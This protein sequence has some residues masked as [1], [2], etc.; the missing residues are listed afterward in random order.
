M[1]RDPPNR[2]SSPPVGTPTAWGGPRGSGCRRT[3]AQGPHM[4]VQGQGQGTGGFGGSQPPPISPGCCRSSLPAGGGGSRGGVPDTPRGPRDPRRGHTG[5]PAGSHGIPGGAREQRRC[6]GM[7]GEPLTRPSPS[8]P[9]WPR[10]RRPPAPQPGLSRAPPGPP[11]PRRR[12][13]HQPGAPGC[14]PLITPG[15][16]RRP[17]PRSTRCPSLCPTAP[18]A[19]ERDRGPTGCCGTCGE[20]TGSRRVHPWGSPRCAEPAEPRTV[21]AEPWARQDGDTACA[22]GAAHTLRISTPTVE[23]LS[24]TAH[25]QPAPHGV[26]SSQ[27]PAAP[28]GIQTSPAMD[29][30]WARPSCT[31]SP[32]RLSTEPAHPRPSPH[33]PWDP[34]CSHRHAPHH[35]WGTAGIPPA[36]LDGARASQTIHNMGLLLPAAATTPTDTLWI[37]YIPNHPQSTAGTPLVAPYGVHTFQTIHKARLG[38]LPPPVPPW[39][40]ME[41]VPPIPQH[42]PPQHPLL[43]TP[44]APQGALPAPPPSRSPRL[45]PPSPRDTPK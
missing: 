3:P 38:P 19:G 44:G 41:P 26:R 2:C 9:A 43:T 37:P 16:G 7:D 40:L 28:Y 23:R 11:K 24:P 4:G 6:R 45:P 39:L 35:P 42:L 13:L 17:P 8:C 33:G 20:V 14:A 31:K 30:G 12:L 18:R 1:T 25:S 36:I 5:S 21:P 29:Q 22:G 15:T 27:S 34:S 10:G 32:A